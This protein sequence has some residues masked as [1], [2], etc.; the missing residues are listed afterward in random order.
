M[1]KGHIELDLPRVRR[2][3]IDQPD[4][5]QIAV[6]KTVAER[7]QGQPMFQTAGLCSRQ[8]SAPPGPF[9]FGIPPR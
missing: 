9:I 3:L 4:V 6:R 2:W 1:A 5:R 7:M 8:C